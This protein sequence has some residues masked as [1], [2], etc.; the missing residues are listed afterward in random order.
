MAQDNAF[1]AGVAHF[2]ATSLDPL[3]P[4][5]RRAILGALLP[6]VLIVYSSPVNQVDA[7]VSSPPGYS[8]P[9]SIIPWG[10]GIAGTLCAARWVMLASWA[11]AAA[12]ALEP[13]SSRTAA[14]SFAWVWYGV[15]DKTGYHHSYTIVLGTLLSLGFLSNPGKQRPESPSLPRS[16]LPRGEGGGHHTEVALNETG[17]CR[18]VITLLAAHCLFAAGVEKVR[19]SGLRW[20]DGGFLKEALLIP[21]CPH[22][23]CIMLP[24]LR[25]LIIESPPLLIALNACSL[26][27]ELGAPGA[28]VFKAWRHFIGLGGVCFHLGILVL[29]RASFTCNCVCY[30]A[31][32]DWQWLAS[33]GA[34]RGGGEA[35]Q[36]AE[37]PSQASPQRLAPPASTLCA[38]GGVA[39][40]LAVCAPT[41]LMVDRWPLLT[42]YPMFSG[43]MNETHIGDF[44]KG[45]YSSLDGLRAIGSSLFSG[46]ATHR[47]I[48]LSV[49]NKRPNDATVKALGRNVRLCIFPPGTPQGAAPWAHVIKDWPSA[50]D[51]SFHEDL[52]ASG[53]LWKKALGLSLA[54]E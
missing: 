20:A 52:G 9:I 36:A 15:I 1:V 6:L 51:C 8:V 21:S 46:K 32:I 53:Y 50:R 28:L 30:L 25:A 33:Y 19:H 37:P 39:L 44:P 45:H 27:L 29:M 3:P 16:D 17:F 10:G 4:N 41:V 24:K 38:A 47:E 22:N 14:A 2:W 42:R 18:M 54:A 43:L 35:L 40:T 7:A 12:G 48:L 11:L 23:R 49:V 31:I 5:V 26:L 13:W 34:R